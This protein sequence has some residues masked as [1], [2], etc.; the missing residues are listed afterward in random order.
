MGGFWILAIQNLT[1]GRLVRN[2]ST[3]F[4]LLS[5]EDTGFKLSP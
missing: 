3:G 1:F 4:I 5:R 2:G